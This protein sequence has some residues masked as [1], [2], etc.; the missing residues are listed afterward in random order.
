MSN[1][2]IAYHYDFTTADSQ[3]YG[4]NLKLKGN[5]FCLFSG[6]VNQNGFIDLDDVIRINNEATNFTVGNYLPED[7][8]GNGIVD[9]EDVTICYNNSVEFV[10][11]I[12]P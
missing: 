6:D 1:N 9:L 8:T 3:A 7:L 12:R 10:S 2:G 11:V 5:E 4:N